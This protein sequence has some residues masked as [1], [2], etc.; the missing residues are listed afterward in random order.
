MP[1]A[2]QMT[3]QG[4]SARNAR[5]IV[6]HSG[7]SYRKRA[8][9]LGARAAH[10]GHG[11]PTGEGWLHL[12]QR[13]R[14]RWGIGR[15]FVVVAVRAAGAGWRVFASPVARGLACA[16][17]A[18]A[19]DGD[20]RAHVVLR[21]SR[22]VLTCVQPVQHRR[23]VTHCP[24]SHDSQVCGQP[25]HRTRSGRGQ[26]WQATGCTPSRRSTQ[27]ST[28]RGSCSVIGAGSLARVAYWPPRLNVRT[29]EPVTRH[30]L[31]GCSHAGTGTVGRVGT[32]ETVR[33]G[34]VRYGAA[35]R[36]A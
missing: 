11:R 19:S 32:R 3:H 35:L 34:A 10:V 21:R 2:A 12:G 30:S 28:H 4:C 18:A 24:V 8:A 31:E 16:A 27:P 25:R 22:Y 15:P 33:C 6:R 17:G 13:R 5:R 7:E 23:R 14:A 1:L 26:C 29:A 20:H 9:C 36:N